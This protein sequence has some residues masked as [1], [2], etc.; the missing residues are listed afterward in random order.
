MLSEATPIPTLVD[1]QIEV[2]LLKAQGYTQ[3]MIALKLG[4]TSGSVAERLTRAR[5]RLGA[6]NTVH[7]IALAAYY[8]I[9][10]LSEIC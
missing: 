3:R 2:L 9:L 4:I 7:A 8:G 10:D 6:N 1:T 5:N